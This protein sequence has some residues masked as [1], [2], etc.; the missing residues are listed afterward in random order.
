MK[1]ITLIT[2]L[3]VF[4]I[5]AIGQTFDFSNSDDG[6]SAVSGFTVANGASFMTLTTVDGDGLL[7]NPACGTTAA[8]VD[9]TVNSFI[10]VTIRNNDATGPDFMRVS[11]P[12]TT[13]GRIYKNLDITTGDGSFV[14]Y[15][16]DLSNVTNWV[17]TMDD[18][19]L[20]F[21]SAGNTDYVLPNNPDNISID[22]DKIEFA[23]ELPRIEKL[24][25][26]FDTDGDAEGYETLVDATS[27]VAGGSFVLTPDGGA[28]AKV[29]NGVNS[30]DADANSHMHI[31]YKNNSATNN[32]LRIQF[33]SSVD[34]YVAF[35]GTNA[36]INPSM[37][38]FETISLDLETLKPT[39]WSQTAQDVQ[40]ALRNTGN[41]ANAADS[42]GTLEIDRIVFNNSTALSIDQL[43][44]TKFSLFPNPAKDA[45]NIT[46]NSEIESVRIFDITGKLV[47]TVKDVIDNKISVNELRTGVYLVNLTFENGNKVSKRLIKE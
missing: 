16:F 40:I 20:H 46:A 14:T 1:K 42:N 22:I 39:E 47:L 34:G 19:K 31:V 28:I 2:I 10:G 37:S 30:V 13:T 36:T 27:N 5:L 9:T 21:K 18:V 38:G 15:W 6:W 44:V 26:E 8:G 11:Y 33:K 32:Q 23:S 17:G 41:A 4:P 29:T 3:L 12:K 7:K 45:I 25:Y 43:E 35:T 24:V